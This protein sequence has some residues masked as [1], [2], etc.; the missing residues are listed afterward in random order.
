MNREIKFRCF[1]GKNMH[2]PEKNYAYHLRWLRTTGWALWWIWEWREKE[3]WSE[4]GENSQYPLMQ[5]T[6]LKDKNGKEIYEGDVV[7]DFFDDII[8]VK[9]LTPYATFNISHFE[10]E[11]IGNIHENPEVV[12]K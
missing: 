3:I 12:C 10:Y 11:I 9:W 8:I 7:K 2:Y 5:Y 1:D 6:G 4:F